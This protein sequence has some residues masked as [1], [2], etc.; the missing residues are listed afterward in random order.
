[1]KASARTERESTKTLGALPNGWPTP[2]APPFPAPTSWRWHVPCLANRQRD[3]PGLY[4]FQIKRENVTGRKSPLTFCSCPLFP[5][6]N[7]V[8]DCSCSHHIKTKTQQAH[9]LRLEEQR[10]RMSL[11]HWYYFTAIALAVARP[12]L[13]LLLC[14]TNHSACSIQFAMFSVIHIWTYSRP[15]KTKKL[16]LRI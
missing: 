6:P 1:M 7:A 12:A 15:I 10:D 11:R 16:Q 14:K 8:N 3:S 13:A 2:P 9:K 5:L 4:P